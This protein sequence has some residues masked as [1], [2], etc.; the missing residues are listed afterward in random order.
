MASQ[1][2]H[3]IYAKKYF[4]SLELK[5]FEDLSPEEKLLAPSNKINKDEFILGCVFPDIRKIDKSIK[6]KDTHLRFEPLDLDFSGLTSFEAGWKFHLYCDMKREEILNKY[7]F[8]VLPRT[9]EMFGQP[10]KMLE[11]ELI[12]EDY[13]NWEKILHYFNNTPYFDSDIDVSSETFGLWYAMVSKYIEKKPDNKSIKIFQSKQKMSIDP[14]ELIQIVDE[15]RKDDRVVGI[16]KK[17][18]DEII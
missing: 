9:T 13:N 3:I 4:D 1:I 14:N 10:A 5:K 18:K 12:Y 17:V 8:Y 16:L 2:A 11:D 6:R 15:L 7:E